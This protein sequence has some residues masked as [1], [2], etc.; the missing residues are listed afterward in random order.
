MRSSPLTRAI[1]PKERAVLLT[2]DDACAYLMSLPTAEIRT[3]TIW[4]RLA[5]LVVKTRKHPTE[6]ALREFTCQLERALFVTR[7]LDLP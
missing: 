1:K 5:A 4:M 6:A 7:H 3:T 2:I